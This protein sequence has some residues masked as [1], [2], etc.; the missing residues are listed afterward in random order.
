MSLSVVIS[1]YN[2]K[3]KLAISLESVKDITDEII[4]VD[5]TSSDG[6]FAL[7]RKYTKH[8]FVRPNN[9][10]LNVNK[11]FGF[12]KATKEW[13]LYLDDDESLTPELR[14]ELKEVFASWNMGENAQITGYWIPRKN[15]IFGKWIEHGIWW[16]DYQMRLFKKG[17][18]MYP[19][20]HVHEM[21][22]VT[23]ET[24]K[25]Q[26]PLYHENYTSISQ[27]LYKLDTFYT[28]NEA[29]RLIAS[30][31][32]LFWHDALKMPMGDFLK[33]F[34]LQEGYKDGLHGLVLSLLQAFYAEIVFAKVWEKQG[35]QAYTSPH[36]L[37]EVYTQMKSLA[38]E[39]KYWMLTTSIHAAKNPVK[40]FLLKIQ[41]KTQTT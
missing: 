32:R 34:F 13:I 28:E 12:T 21:I 20:K 29:E 35:F 25:L 26:N 2:R 18:G 31:K 33:T 37:Q 7:A 1:T 6:S 4:V 3:E 9:P 39:C 11:N 27:Y 22:K 41:R 19:E 36:F 15:M 40:K 5:N 23:G 14:E 16:P 24:A 17:K 30:D 10:M 8:V 38:K